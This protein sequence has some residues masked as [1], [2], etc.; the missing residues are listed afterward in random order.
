MRLFK[1]GRAELRS[2]RRRR[3][4]VLARQFIMYWMAR[5]TTYSLPQIGRLIGN[6][7]HTTVLYGK[8]SYVAKRAKMGRSL[9]SL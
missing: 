1:V 6:R 8:R 9:R 7:D 3:D 5:L 4:L 2:A